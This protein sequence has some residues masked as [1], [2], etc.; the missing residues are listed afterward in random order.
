MPDSHAHSQAAYWSICL[1]I[2]M[3]LIDSQVIGAIAPQIA[4]G[5]GAPKTSVASSAATYSIANAAVAFGLGAFGATVRPAR[6]LIFAA[7]LAVVAA[8]VAALSPNI[9]VFHLA[10]ATA[11]FSGGLTSALGISA[12]ANASS[13]AKRGSQMS[14]VAVS[15]F[16]APVVGVPLGTFLT[17]QFGW[18]APFW[19]AAGLVT[20]AGAL[21]ARFP[22]ADEASAGRDSAKFTPDIRIFFKLWTLATRSRSTLF[23]V[24]SAA[25]VSGGLVGFSA[26]LGTWLSDAFLASSNQIGFAFGVTGVAAIIGGMLGGKLADRFGKRRVALHASLWMAAFLLAVPTFAW[27]WGLFAAIAAAALAAAVR[28]APLQALVT[29]M[30]PPSERPT[31]IALRNAVSQLGIVAGVS[32]SGIGYAGFGFWGVG[33]TCSLLTLTAWALIRIIVDPKPEGIRPPTGALRRSAGSPLVVRMIKFAVVTIAL[34]GLGFP[35]AVSFLVTKAKTR[36]DELARTDTPRAYGAEYEDVTFDSSGITL[37]GWYLPSRT[38]QISVVMTHGLF[39]SRYEMLERAIAMWKLGYGVLLYDLRRHGRSPGEYCSVGYYER[40]DVKSAADWVRRRAPYDKIVLMGVSMG[41]AATLMAAAETPGVTAVIA[42][43]GFRSFQQTVS[44]DVK[45]LGLP[46]TPF[47]WL[48]A[49]FTA[50]RLGFRTADFDVE[51]AVRSIHVPILFISGD[52]DRRMPPDITLEP[53]Y[54]AAPNPLKS[55]MIIPGARHGRAY[56]EDPKRY[57][58][59]VDAFLRQATIQPSSG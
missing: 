43:S 22:L 8:V 54:A 56:D 57:V 33:L 41:A 16:L 38:K 47:A 36:P 55:K 29:E 46:A 31:Y 44:T 17:G 53:L 2:L 10:R 13:Y 37:S 52:K 9:F 50:W 49:N 7:A 35:Y 3:A 14:G 28:V 6:G 26:F 45:N 15:Y 32:L 42:E 18:A 40:R 23:G 34:I 25:F 39:R 21:V 1:L 59:T 24:I 58:E 30:A 5:L 48:M 20:A 11:G 4:A 51:R 12:L 19:C 27:T